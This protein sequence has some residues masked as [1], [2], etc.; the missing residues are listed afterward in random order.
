MPIFAST[1]IISMSLASNS[2]AVA[3]EVPNKLSVDFI[4]FPVNLLGQGTTLATL[5]SATASAS[6]G[7][8]S[9]FN[10]VIYSLGSGANSQSLQSVVSASAGFTFSQQISITNSTQGSYSQGY[11]AQANGQGTTLTT[12]Y[13]ISNT[14]YSFVSNTIVSLFSG[15]RMIDIPFATT[16]APGNYWM[17]AGMSSS[18]ASAGAALAAMSNCAVRY[19]HHYAVGQF[20]ASIGIMGSTNLSSGGL[21]G[22]GSYSF[23]AGGGGTTASIPMSLISSNASN[24]KLYFQ[25]L[26]SA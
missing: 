25:M 26:R 19:T 15:N 11:S 23:T 8:F 1:Q 3:F 21:F 4:R 20:T 2:F 16:L 14:N 18:S 7:I 13:S 22:A 24:A 9:T 5:A 17:V 6:N 10:A 12:Q